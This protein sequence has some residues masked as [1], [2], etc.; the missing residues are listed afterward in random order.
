[1]FK[2]AVLI[3]NKS[4][5]AKSTKICAFASLLGKQWDKAIKTLI[6]NALSY[7]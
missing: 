4:S 2:L 6:L 5:H 1:M 7:I 3:P